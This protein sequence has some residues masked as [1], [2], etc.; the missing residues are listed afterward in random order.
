MRGQFWIVEDAIKVVLVLVKRRSTIQKGR[1]MIID[2]R[3]RRRFL[4]E[5]DEGATRIAR[6]GRKH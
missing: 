6:G 2:F 3:C 1:V 5:T 4:F